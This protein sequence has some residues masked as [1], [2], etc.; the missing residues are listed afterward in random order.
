MYP[1]VSSIV[2]SGSS[3][4]WAISSLALLA[5]STFIILCRHLIKHV[6]SVMKRLH[7]HSNVVKVVLVV[8]ALIVTLA[9]IFVSCSADPVDTLFSLL[10]PFDLDVTGGYKVSVSIPSL[11][12]A[13]LAWNAVL[14]AGLTR[15]PTRPASTTRAGGSLGLPSVVPGFVSRF[16][17][18]T[19]PSKGADNAAPSS[20]HATG[21]GKPELKAVQAKHQIEIAVIQAELQAQ[22]CASEA[23]TRKVQ[24]MLVASQ[25]D[26][27]R[28][29]NEI[30]KVQAL[31]LALVVKDQE[32]TE[33]LDNECAAH[34]AT[35]E[36]LE[37]Q[38]AAR[39]RAEAAYEETR[40]QKE[41]IAQD[42]S[43][44][45]SVL[46]EKYEKS[47]KTIR[48]YKKRLEEARQDCGRYAE[49]YMEAEQVSA[50]LSDENDELRSKVGDLE[51]ALNA[52]S[53]GHLEDQLAMATLDGADIPAETKSDAINELKC[54]PAHANDLDVSV[55]PNAA[56]ELLRS[57]FEVLQTD[58]AERATKAETLQ[59]EVRD[60]RAEMN[61]QQDRVFK[62]MQM[63]AEESGRVLRNSIKLEGRLARMADDNAYLQ[64]K[65][66]EYKARI[67]D[68]KQYFDS[69]EQQRYAKE[70][71]E[72]KAAQRRGSPRK[73]KVPVP[74][75]HA[76][77][78]CVTVDV[79]FL[80]VTSPSTV[81]TASSV[82]DVQECDSQYL[83][84]QFIAALH[85][86]ESLAT[87]SA[88]AEVEETSD[89]GRTLT[90]HAVPI[91][92]TPRA[93]HRSS[94]S[95]VENRPPLSSASHV[96]GTRIPALT[97]QPNPARYS[98]PPSKAA[99][100]TGLARPSSIPRAKRASRS[101][102]TALAINFAK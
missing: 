6:R 69:A 32:R 59:S 92:P 34:E 80:I 39:L 72:Y 99:T 10:L 61:G 95:S 22:V 25:N 85:S 82:E 70:K 2:P 101:P 18:R 29:N 36:K 98:T 64:M 50:K 15:A 100:A 11:V 12:L 49:M 4:L 42:A 48:L 81:S 27:G 26:C 24:A 33:A 84:P 90:V 17:A 89:A 60:L 51:S 52:V 35:Q 88:E 55:C 46:E 8:I 77:P 28:K 9:L 45:C 78:R 14:I 65:L 58:L 68:Y 67:Q 19:Y 30:E 57:R 23:Y 71:Q 94:R 41:A 44:R 79:P 21:H 16:A 97:R 62:G 31:C 83:V 38:T 54:D 47:Q 86:C 53:T 43:E 13:V 56:C 75:A 37:E 20:A 93:Q 66:Q 1:T 87:L 3:S 5:S 73:A 102:L 76:P 91:T 96:T 63:H 40:T 74:P 7:W